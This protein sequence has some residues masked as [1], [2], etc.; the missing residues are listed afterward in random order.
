MLHGSHSVWNQKTRSSVDRVHGYGDN[1]SNRSN[2]L[3][4]PQ[5]MQLHILSKCNSQY[6]VCTANCCNTL[7]GSQASRKRAAL[8]SRHRHTAE[9]AEQ[10]CAPAEQTSSR[11]RSSSHIVRA[12][13]RQLAAVSA[14]P[15]AEP[16]RL[17]VP[18]ESQGLLACQT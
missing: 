12:V 15:A 2:Q 5:Q 17:H 7:S 16:L 8:Q 14:A 10:H 11:V 6:R 13:A 3:H 9:Q 1:Q 18:P 4:V